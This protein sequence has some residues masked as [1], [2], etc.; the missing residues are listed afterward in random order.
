MYSAGYQVFVFFL[1]FHNFLYISIFGAHLLYIPNLEDAAD[2]LNCLQKNK[3]SNRTC[4]KVG[5]DKKSVESR[6]RKN[7]KLLLLI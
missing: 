1:F 2:N 6:K 3:S 5:D 7:L 4:K